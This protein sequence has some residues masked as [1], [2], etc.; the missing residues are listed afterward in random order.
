MMGNVQYIT[1]FLKGID[2]NLSPC[3]WG[4]ARPSLRPV[5]EHCFDGV[6]RGWYS[7]TSIISMASSV[8]SSG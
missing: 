3:K 7:D 6:R 5:E 4:M 8:S 1:R 2:K